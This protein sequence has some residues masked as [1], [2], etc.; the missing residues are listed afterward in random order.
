MTA[1]SPDF[2]TVLAHGASHRYAG[3][4]SAA[5]RVMTGATLTL[6]SG[7]VT[8]DYPDAPREPYACPL[9]RGVLP[10]TP[11]VPP[12]RYPVHL[13]VADITDGGGAELGSRVAAV[14][15]VVRDKP[16][17]AWDIHD[18]Y[19][20]G[21]LAG[22]KKDWFTDSPMGLIDCQTCGTFDISAVRRC[23]ALPRPRRRQLRLPG[24]GRR[25]CDGQHRRLVH[26][27]VRHRLPG[28]E[29]LPVRTGQGRDGVLPDRL[30]GRSL[31]HLGRARRGRPDRPRR[32]WISAPARPG[33]SR[34]PALQWS[35]RSEAGQE[36]GSRSAT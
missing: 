20:D 29:R 17:L 12:G 7:Y 36:F 6:T 16:A 23:Q 32:P 5:I 22:S 35:S 24:R 27:P 3:G 4:E 30:G 21:W 19:P 34:H 18:D 9:R 1:H 11:P 10:E 31:P 14:R 26:R 33:I 28:R 13:I 8:F 25:P 2:D 15:L